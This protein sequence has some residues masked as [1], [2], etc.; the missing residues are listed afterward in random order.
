MLHLDQDF[1]NEAFGLK[2]MEGTKAFSIFKTRSESWQSFIRLL[3]T[4]WFISLEM[5][6]CIS[7]KMKT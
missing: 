4:C 6:D 3:G 5:M 1:E 7:F 2:G